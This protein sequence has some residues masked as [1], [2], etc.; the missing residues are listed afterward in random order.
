MNFNLFPIARADVRR[1]GYERGQQLHAL[2]VQLCALRQGGVREAVSKLRGIR[3]PRRTRQRGTPG[4]DAAKLGR[5]APEDGPRMNS[6]SQLLARLWRWY[7]EA[8]E[9]R[10]RVRARARF[11][12]ELREGEREA[13]ARPRP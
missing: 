10:R 2:R 1:R 13:E 4:M 8:R 12:A 7:Q 6:L 5:R 9:E 11:W 3:R